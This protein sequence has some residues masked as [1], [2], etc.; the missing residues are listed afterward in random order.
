M[1][2]RILGL[3]VVVAS[4]GCDV[5]E[6]AEE[7]QAA[8]ATPGVYV[9][10]WDGRRWTD[11]VVRYVIDKN[12]DWLP[13][14]PCDFDGNVMTDETE[15]AIKQGIAEYEALTPVNFIR[16][17]KANPPPPDSAY[18]IYRA[19]TGGSSAEIRGMPFPTE[20]SILPN[21][22]YIDPA[23]QPDED[24]RRSV[25]HETGHLLGFPHEQQRPDRDLFV[26][27]DPFCIQNDDTGKLFGEDSDALLLTPYDIRSIM[28]YQSDNSCSTTKAGCRND[29]GDCIR[30]PLLLAEPP[31]PDCITTS[32]PS[33]ADCRW[34]FRPK[35]LSVHDVNALARMYEQPLGTDDPDDEL[36]AAIAVGDF[37][38]DGYD[39]VAVGAPEDGTRGAV[40]LW[41]GTGGQLPDT[42]GRLVAW[43]K[44][45][46]RD[47]GPQTLAYSAGRFGAALAA[48]DF[49]DDGATDL[50][51]GAPETDSGDLDDGS[52]FIY[53]SQ[54][55][56]NSPRRTLTHTRVM[57]Q[58]RL[59]R[60]AGEP[61]DRFGQALAAAD[62]D[63]DGF[64]DLAIGV[65]RKRVGGVAC[66][67]VVIVSGRTQRPAIVTPLMAPS[68]DCVAGAR[69]GAALAANDLDP[70]VD[71]RDELVVGSPENA[72]DP[73][74][75]GAV[76]L[77]SVGLFRGGWYGAQLLRPRSATTEGMR[78]GAALAT[79]NYDGSR[80]PG[81]RGERQIAVGAPYRTYRSSNPGL[82]VTLPEAGAV[83]LYRPVSATSIDYVNVL[84]VDEAPAPAT[85]NHFGG[86]LATWRPSDAVNDRL[87]AGLP[88]AGSVGPAAGKGR[89]EVYRWTSLAA[90]GQ[91]AETLTPPSTVNGGDR[92]GDALASGNLLP[93][94]FLSAGSVELLV[95]APGTGNGAGAYHVHNLDGA[96]T[97]PWER[98]QQSTA[99]HE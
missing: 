95:G 30:P 99:S 93:G 14:N 78:F 12:A 83:Y 76:Y 80:T 60:G 27:Y 54:P 79:G 42:L 90:S 33:T 62:F 40:Y 38:D 72:T 29:D 57:N 10:P 63:G 43:R 96:F 91:L 11:G 6:L 81:H 59:F 1:R 22:V 45:S 5:L 64:K 26:T 82:Q 3:V 8:S 34:I 21:C 67:E 36:G 20:S 37:D 88:D 66:G 70:D 39:D 74:R 55:V 56:A 17:T 61:G 69:F 2:A 84:R 75:N 71:D 24:G 65:P 46:P 9:M 18:V 86:V 19:S 92:F 53:E 50:A 52:V 58:L 97:S 85:G 16:H 4:A 41:K 15:E 87:A 23:T 89:V 25:L 13:A 44:L 68:G 73:V 77:F 98:F 28:H 31:T 48:G 47:V 94:F 35:Q 7:T 32:P 49:N 51:I